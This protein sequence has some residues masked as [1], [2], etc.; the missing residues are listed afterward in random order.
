MQQQT[1]A[2]PGNQSEP[3]K[4]R[5]AQINFGCEKEDSLL[6]ILPRALVRN[7]KHLPQLKACNFF[8]LQ[9]P[10]PIYILSNI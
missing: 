2:I 5:T 9:K 8:G 6:D 10:R 3:G 4:I 1:P 7:Q